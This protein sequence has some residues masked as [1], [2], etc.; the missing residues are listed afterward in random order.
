MKKL[1][2]VDLQWSIDFSGLADLKYLP[3]KSF[4][5]GFTH[6]QIFIL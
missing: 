6:E 1:L 3:I 4:S 5:K 2:V